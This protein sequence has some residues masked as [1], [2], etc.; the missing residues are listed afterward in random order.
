MRVS[1][2][3]DEVADPDVFVARLA[4]GERDAPAVGGQRHVGEPRVLAPDRPDHLAGAVHPDHLPRALAP[5]S[6]HVEQRAVVRDAHRD[7]ARGDQHGPR[8]LGAGPRSYPIDQMPGLASWRTNSSRPA[9]VRGL[10]ESSPPRSPS[11]GMRWCPSNTSTWVRRSPVLS[12]PDLPVH[13]EE[14]VPVRQPRRARGSPPS[15][16][17]RCRGA[18]P[19]SRRPAGTWYIPPRQTEKAIDPERDQVTPMMLPV[20]G[21]SQIAI[22]AAALDRHLPEL[23]AVDERQRTGIGRPADRREPRHDV[24]NGARREPVQVPHPDPVP[25]KVGDLRPSGESSGVGTRR[26]RCRSRLRSSFRSGPVRWR[27]RISARRTRRAS[28]GR[29]QRRHRPDQDVPP[30]RWRRR[31][32]VAAFFLDRRREHDARFADVAQPFLRVLGQAAREQR[33]APAR[34]VS[35]GSALQS[36]SRLA[37]SSRSCPRR[38]RLRTPAARSGTRRARSRTTRCRSACPPRARAPARGSCTRRCRG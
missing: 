36:G 23:L 4:R 5:R 17:D 11:I 14:E 8:S 33:R 3:R 1:M 9:D 21:I 20:P 13:G 37:G 35:A 32:G 7:R 22:G 6:L 15:L 24:G 27:N 38:S 25:R 16:P 28:P 30:G 31:R 26:P 2:P 19:A 34:G 10:A 12:V 18:A 29:G